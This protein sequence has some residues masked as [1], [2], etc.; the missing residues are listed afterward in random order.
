MGRGCSGPAPLLK[1]CCLELVVQDHVQMASEYL[2]GGSLHHLSGQ[3]V[4]V[5]SHPH[6][7][8][9]FSGVRRE[10]RVFQS[11]HWAPLRRACLHPLYTL[12]SGVSTHWPDPPEPSLLQ[13]ETAPPLSA[14][15][16]RSGD[17]A[18]MLP[19]IWLCQCLCSFCFLIQGI[20]AKT[21]KR[22]FKK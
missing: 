11:R 17:L 4:P 7:E 14:F 22:A 21:R 5:L 9:G 1:L 12:L 2:Q 13:S 15:H 19:G 20:V 6:S 3:C 16:H 8:K 10:P 18:Q